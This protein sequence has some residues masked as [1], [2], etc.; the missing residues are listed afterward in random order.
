MNK[1]F[2]FVAGI[3]VIVCTV[4]FLVYTA[5]DQTKM[6]MITVGEF[7]S[8]GSAYAGTTLR[9]AGRVRE[10]SMVWDSGTN[11]LRFTLIDT[12]GDSELAVHYTGILPDM[13]SE[14]RDVVVEG[15]Y[16]ATETFKAS[17]V[18]TSCPSKYE[19]EAPH[20]AVNQAVEN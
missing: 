8:A 17:T 11:D 3:A 7:V 2:K 12:E 18:L 10:N 5:V 16:P 9:V 19:A 6:Y 13:F 15:P 4:A 14:G 20:P 1:Q